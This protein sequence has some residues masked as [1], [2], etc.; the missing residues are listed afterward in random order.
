MTGRAYQAEHSL[1]DRLGVFGDGTDGDITV[2]SGSFDLA[3]RIEDNSLLTDLHANNLILN[4]G[5]LYANGFLIRVNGTLTLT[6]GD[7]EAV[8]TPRVGTNGTDPDGGTGGDND[9]VAGWLRSANGKN[10]GAGAEDGNGTAGE[11]ASSFAWKLTAPPAG[12]AGGDAGGNTGGAGGAAGTGG[13]ERGRFFLTLA[14]VLA[15]F[16]KNVPGVQTGQAAAGGGGASAVAGAIGGGG[17][18]AGGNGG[19]LV[20]AARRIVGAGNLRALGGNGGSGGNATNGGAGAAG[21]GGGGNGGNG[22]NIILITQDN[23]GWSGAMIV[24][25]GTGGSGGTGIGGGSNGGN[26]ANGNAGQTLAIEV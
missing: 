20:I 4:G 5:D 7:C 6:S 15:L 13:A 23:Y 1:I 9:D 14:D 16:G 22:G 2:N 26:G 17:G 24:T 11:D 21:G 8:A 10:G 12:A 18:G 3:N 25:G 19:W